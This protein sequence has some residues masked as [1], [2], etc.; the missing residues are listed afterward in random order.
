MFHHCP[1]TVYSLMLLWRTRCSVRQS[2]GIERGGGWTSHF[3]TELKT[4]CET[5]YSQEN[6][7]ENGA[8]PVSVS[9]CRDAELFIQLL[10]ES[11]ERPDISALPNGHLVL[12]WYGG[13]R[14]SL[15]VTFCG[16]STIIYLGQ[17]N[18]QEVADRATLAGSIPENVLDYLERIVSIAV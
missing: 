16:D 11:S 13:P 15:S 5:E 14:S 4:V 6:W 10:P 2:F 17:L 18:E 9:S 1:F 12:E 3:L 8:Q 7:D